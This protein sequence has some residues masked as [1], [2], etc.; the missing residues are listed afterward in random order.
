MLAHLP[1]SQKEVEDS[2][3]H[4][5]TLTLGSVLQMPQSAAHCTALEIFLPT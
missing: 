4:V 1:E 5:L 3:I 2:E